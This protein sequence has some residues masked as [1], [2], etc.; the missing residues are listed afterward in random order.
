MQIILMESPVCGSVNNLA[1]I[2]QKWALVISTHHDLD[3]LF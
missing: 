2:E 1:S 3:N